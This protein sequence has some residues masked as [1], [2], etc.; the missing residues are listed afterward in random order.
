VDLCRRATDTISMLQNALADKR[1]AC[2]NTLGFMKP[3]IARIAKSGFMQGAHDGLYIKVSALLA[4]KTTDPLLAKTI[5][6]FC[7]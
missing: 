3:K 5:E 4:L 7:V 1:C 2:V 6:A